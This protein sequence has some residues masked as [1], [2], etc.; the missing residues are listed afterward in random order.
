MKSLF[1]ID[2]ILYPK[3]MACYFIAV[4][5]IPNKKTSSNF[6]TT[7]PWTNILIKG[8]CRVIPPLATYPMIIIFQVD[9]S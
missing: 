5:I 2:K 9:E 4:S 3:N 7:Y 1:E 6:R 8:N